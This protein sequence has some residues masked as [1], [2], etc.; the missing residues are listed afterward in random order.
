VLALLASLALGCSSGGSAPPVSSPEA[1][2]FVGKILDDDGDP[3]VGALVS[4]DGIEANAPTDATGQFVVS[5]PSL[6][7]STAS[8]GASANAGQA[9]AAA[10]GHE[11]AVIAPGFQ[12]FFGTILVASGEIARIDVVR[13]GLEPVLD[14]VSPTEGQVFTIPAECPE[15]S[16]DVSGFVDL[17]QRE[18]LLLDIVVVI[19]ASGSTSDP[20][21]G[22]DGATVLDVEKEAIACFLEGLDFSRTRVALTQFNDSAQEVVGM[23]NDTSLLTAGL[24]SIAESSGGTNFEAAFRLSQTILE[25]TIAEDLEDAEASGPADEGG[26]VIV[27]DTRRVVVMLSDGVPTTHGVP[28]DPTDSNLTQTADDRKAATDAARDLGDATGAEFYGYT[29]VSRDTT[30]RKFT[31]MPHCVA[32][33]GGGQHIRVESPADLETELCGEDLVNV[34]TVRARN[35]TAGTDDVVATLSAGGKFTVSLPV[36][37]ALDGSPREN[38]IVVIATAFPGSLNAEVSETVRVVAMSAAHANA[39]SF[40]EVN[41]L[42]RDDDSVATKG[43]VSKPSG[44]AVNG[45]DIFNFLAGTDAEFEDAVQLHGVGALTVVDAQNSGADTVEITVDVL[46]KN[47]CYQSDFGFL[48]FDDDDLP[49]SHE[50]ALRFATTAENVF[51]NTGSL[52]NSCTIGSVAAGTSNFTVDVPVGQAVVFFLLPDFTLNQWHGEPK[53]GRKPLFTLAKINPALE[54]QVVAFVSDLGR[55]VAGAST[56]LVTPGAHL[57]YSFEDIQIAGKG[58][59]EDFG[60]L[61]FSVRTDGHLVASQILCPA[62]AP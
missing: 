14:I 37:A 51:L 45:T 53:K 33:C 48:L 38:E 35:V 6:A 28:R 23:T 42:S 3:V 39:L 9:L 27:H 12:P 58:S 5:D 41:D 40:A 56:V 52:G 43:F 44:G 46:Y 29:I 57:I 30:A 20:A 22:T 54:V 16:V 1:G 24:A 19:D 17:V 55:S 62:D 11:F 49:R 25:D 4:V 59:D 61:V 32:V 47:A 10:V 31:T 2:V 21:A 34:V 60:D 26:D 13:Q 36:V 7:T 50:Q 18:T 15:A 8:L